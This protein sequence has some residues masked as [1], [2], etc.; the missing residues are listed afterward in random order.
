MFIP[1][2]FSL[3]NN[4]KIHQGQKNHR[5]VKFIRHT[6]VSYHHGAFRHLVQSKAF[7]RLETDTQTSSV[8][9]LPLGFLYLTTTGFFPQQSCGSLLFK[10]LVY[11]IKSIYLKKIFFSKRLT[12]NCGLSYLI[13]AVTALG[14]LTHNRYFPKEGAYA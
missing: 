3:N 6:D 4:K 13:R 12:N 10:N 1:F 14:H 7:F 9:H 5:V 2:M 11:E 8:S